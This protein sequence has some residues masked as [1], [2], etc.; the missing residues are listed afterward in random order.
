MSLV[1]IFMRKKNVVVLMGGYSSEYE[2]SIL[3]G[4]VVVE[5]LSPEKYHVYPVYIE[6]DQW[7]YLAPDQTKHP[8]HPGN[9]SFSA[10]TTTIVPDVVYNTIHGTP[11]EDGLFSAY[12]ELLGIPHTS[13]KHYPAALTMNKRDCLTVLK[14][15]G[16]PCAR[17]YYINQGD[18]INI[19]EIIKI[20]GLPCFVKP[21]KSGSSFG[22]SK[23][24]ELDDFAAAFEK[25]FQEDSEILVEAEISGVEVSV[26]AMR[27]NGAVFV[28]P[29]TEIVSENEFFDYE[30]KY[31]GKSQE[32]TPARISAEDTQRVQEL[33]QRIYQL[34]NLSGITRTDFIIQDGIPY[35]IEVNTTPGLS[36]E[37]IIPK[38]AQA[39]GMTL[40][41]LF[42]ELIEQALLEK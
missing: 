17:S 11:G 16:V 36:R 38:Q 10:G 26:G 40:T 27:K 15:F 35:F 23:V 3:S 6:K 39:V 22:I 5:S 7:Y 4:Q 20:T 19:E 34:L 25:A 12:L 32:I 21:S 33:T 8:I 1:L 28:F 18:A 42:G 2:I 30:A 14:N 24:K 29:P 41:E 37:S 13:C 31:L 9:F